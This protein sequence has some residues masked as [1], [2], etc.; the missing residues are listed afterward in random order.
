MPT[1]F[2]IYLDRAAV[3]PEII[4]AAAAVTVNFGASADALIDVLQNPKLAKGKLPMDLP[5][6]MEAVRDSK[7]DLP[8]DTPDPLFRFGDG[9]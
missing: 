8:F 9:L 3:F 4:Q 6:S 7:S 5:S 1:I 2:D